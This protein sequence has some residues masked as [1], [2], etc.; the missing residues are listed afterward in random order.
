MENLKDDTGCL[1]AILDNNTEQLEN[2][3]PETLSSWSKTVSLVLNVKNA[4]SGVSALHQVKTQADHDVA[5]GNKPLDY[6]N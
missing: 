6:E 1:Q 3:S 4:V 2:Q 5:H